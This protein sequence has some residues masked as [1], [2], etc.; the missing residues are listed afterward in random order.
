VPAWRLD[1]EV[2]PAAVGLDPAKLDAIAADFH[3]A[4]EGQELFGGAQ[5]ALFRD[6][7]RVLDLGGGFSG[8]VADPAPL[9]PDSLFVIFSAS[10][11]L[12]ALAMLIL[13]ERFQLHFDEP[14]MRY[15]P[16]FADSVPEKA[17]VTIRQVLSHRAGFP[18]G[19]RWLVPALWGDREAIRRAAEEAPVV[20]PPGAKNG[21]HEMTFGHV[22]NELLLRIDGRHCGRFLADEVFGP[23]GLHDI[24][25]GL[26]AGAAIEARVAR[27]ESAGGDDSPFN[28]AAV[29]R[30]VLPAAGAIAA[31]RD[32]GRVFAALACGGS[33]EG[34]RL[35]SEAG[36]EATTAPTNR[37]GEIDQSM[38]LPMR[39][40]TGWQLGGFGGG[41][42]RVFGHMGRG[43][44]V[45]YA[46]RERRLAFAFLTTGFRDQ[47]QGL[48]WR[49]RLGT[50]AFAAC[51]D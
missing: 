26:P 13:Y 3:A 10:K 31:A 15:W 36:L 22:V 35:V 19:P 46:D 49:S 40:G 4:V 25:L 38:R 32:L 1:P 2:D 50:L 33:L 51:R 28:L 17:Q 42:L 30:A 24:Y 27:I 44:Q 45:V 12:A 37:A 43:G 6:G 39:W 7:R 9:G 29:H 11:G 47:A 23:L 34:V 20:W 8:G 18:H 21:Y 5:L 48:I 16:S 14:V 41:G